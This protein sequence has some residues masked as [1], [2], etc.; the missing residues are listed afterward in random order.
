M[1]ERER[2]MMS[3]CQKRRGRAKRQENERRRWSVVRS[4]RGDLR[5]LDWKLGIVRG[6]L[7]VEDRK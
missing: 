3:R 5:K 2:E 1:R 6:K 4:R 7:E